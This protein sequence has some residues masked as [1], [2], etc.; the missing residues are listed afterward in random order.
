METT[1]DAATRQRGRTHIFP[2]LVAIGGFVAGVIAIGW[3]VLKNHGFPLDDSWIHQVVGRNAAEY[4]IPGF[5]PGIA[6]SGSSSAIWPWIIAVNYRFLPGVEPST[7]LLA[8]N[9]ALFAVVLVALWFAAQRDELPP[10]ERMAL[11]ALPAL[12]GNFA[13]LVSTGMEHLLLVATTFLSAHFLFTRRPVA[14]L[15]PILVAGVLLGGAIVTRPEAVVFVPLF[16]AGAY[17]TTRR[18]RSLFVLALPCVAAISFVVANNWLTS[19]SLL[20]VT[21]SGRKWLNFGTTDTFRL[22]IILHFIKACL[23]QVASTFVDFGKGEL[24]TVAR[25]VISVAIGALAVFATIRLV[26]RRAW[27]TLFLIALSLANFGAY[28]FLFPTIGHGMRYQAMLLVF[29][30]PMIALGLLELGRALARRGGKRGAA[31]WSQ[32]A[33]RR[34]DSLALCFTFAL[35]LASLVE[36]SNI[37]DDGIQHING[38]HVRMGEWLADHLPADAKVASFDIG[39]IGFYS[40]RRI[41]DLGGLVDSEFTPYLFAGKTAEYLRKEGIEWLVLPYPP[42]RPGTGEAASCAGFEILLNLCDGN[43]F[44][45]REVVAYYTPDGIWEKAYQATGHAWQGQILYEIDWH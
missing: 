23:F 12:Y 22:G 32:Q 4:G 29:V 37:A 13:W 6:S 11:V 8:L 20:P 40:H 33:R 44:T 26:R 3:P 9:V 16:L 7:F 18:W 28:F 35:A 19:H 1:L 31:G 27:R 34:Y 42:A 30:L 36:W 25:I 5:I 2:A 17:L 45:K 41:Y 14:G 10:L 38:T 39:G 21:V 43:G 15:P 24:S